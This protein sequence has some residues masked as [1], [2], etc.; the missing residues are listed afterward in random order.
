MNARPPI[1]FVLSNP[2]DALPRIAPLRL[3][4]IAPDDARAAR[5]TFDDRWNALVDKIP[6]VTDWCV[7]IDDTRPGHDPAPPFSAPG[8]ITLV[9]Q[10][11]TLSIEFDLAAHPALSV[12]ASHVDSAR[13]SERGMHDALAC[14]LLA[15]LMA[16]LEQTGFTGWQVASL[17]R[18]RG[19][20]RPDR[21][22]AASCAS[23][24]FLFNGEGYRAKVALNRAFV[25]EVER[26]LRTV[27]PALALPVASI[28]VPGRLRIGSKRYRTALL[29]SLEPGDVLPGAIEA[30]L[31]I[32]GTPFHTVATWGTTRGTRLLA[33]VKLVGRTA[34]LLKDP[35][36]E[37]ETSHAENDAPD[38]TDPVDVGALELPVN[39]EIDTI[40][41]SVDQLAALRAGYVF[42]L[43]RA[44]SEMRIRLVA[45]GQLIGHGE[46]VTVG[47]HLGVR[48]LQMAQRDDS[49]R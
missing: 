30:A 33:P 12:V 35:V 29:R 48:I 21:P 3:A 6:G 16:T 41:V 31:R 32:T 1:A 13:P 36:M 28:P 46:L 26:L 17:T 8:L 25:H 24:S 4:N 45:H 5:L 34:V 9:R 20:A 10:T 38:R 39:F 14:A 11:E 47:E 18:A 23:L 43:A 40:A 44:P 15:P 7:S 37:Q 42:E 2:N 19:D 27:S 49:G 22:G